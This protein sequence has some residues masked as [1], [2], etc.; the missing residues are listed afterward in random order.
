MQV[1]TKE[2]MFIDVQRQGGE[3]KGDMKRPLK[4]HK[5]RWLFANWWSKDDID[6][7]PISHLNLNYELHKPHLMSLI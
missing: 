6:V 1:D 3:M 5:L 2:D 4:N 7:E